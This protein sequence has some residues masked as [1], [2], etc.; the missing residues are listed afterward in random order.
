MFPETKYSVEN[1]KMLQLHVI[2]K[3]NLSPEILNFC[4]NYTIVKVGMFTKHGMEKFAA[5]QAKCKYLNQDFYPGSV[6][7]F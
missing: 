5:S 2:E 4:G 1:L 3:K 6:T 7:I